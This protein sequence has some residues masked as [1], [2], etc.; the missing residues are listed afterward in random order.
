MHPFAELLEKNHDDKKHIVWNSLGTY[1]NSVGSVY[2]RP[3][4]NQVIYRNKRQNWK[5]HLGTNVLRR[6]LLV[7]K[8]HL[9]NE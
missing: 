3:Q 7:V 6:Q 8:I 2:Y 4:T 1:L 9:K 5:T